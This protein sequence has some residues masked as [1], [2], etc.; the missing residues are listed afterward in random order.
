VKRSNK[1]IGSS[2][3]GEPDPSDSNKSPSVTIVDLSKRRGVPIVTIGSGPRAFV[4]LLPISGTNPEVPCG[5]DVLRKVKR[6]A[7]RYGPLDT[8]LRR[9]TKRNRPS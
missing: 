7:K 6:A 2:P 5:D 3:D 8:D 1:S 9:E 4:K